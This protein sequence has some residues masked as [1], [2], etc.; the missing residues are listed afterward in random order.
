M[1]N[2][3][4]SGWIEVRLE[5]TRYTVQ[6]GRTVVIPVEIENTGKV[7]DHLEFSIL[8][9]PPEWLGAP[10][11]I[12]ML[13]VGE[14]RQVSLVI[15]PPPAT[16]LRPGVYPLQLRISSLRLQGRTIELDLLLTVAAESV[17]GTLAAYLAQQEYVVPP[18]G[19]VA[20]SLVVVNNYLKKDRFR[21]SA[22]GLPSGWISAD[23]A[24]IELKPGEEAEIRLEIT[25]PHSSTSLAG[26]YPFNL[27]LSAESEPKHTAALSCQLTV[28]PYYS[29]ELELL[30]PVLE[31]GD[32]GRVRLQNQGNEEDIYTL[33]FDSTQEK[34]SFHISSPLVEPAIPLSEPAGEARLMPWGVAHAEGRT[35]FRGD[36]AGAYQGAVM[37]IPPGQV[38]EIEFRVLSLHPP[39]FQQSVESFTVESASRRQ[40][41]RS[42]SGMAEIAP[43]AYPLM[44][45][46]VMLLFFFTLAISAVLLGM[47]AIQTQVA[48]VSTRGTPTPTYVVLTAFPTRTQTPT[49]TL[50]P[51]FTQTIMTPT[52]TTTGTQTLGTPSTTPTVSLTP[53][54]TQTG[55][56]VPP[57][58]TVTR[59]ATT[60][61][62]IFPILNTGRIAYD[63]TIGGNQELFVYD[64]SRLRLDLLYQSPGVDTQP[65]W[66]PD[67]KRLAFASNQDGNF[68]I[69]IL[70]L[71]TGVVYNLTRNPADDRYP[72]WSPDGQQILFTTDR[73]G[74][75]EIY[76]TT[77]DA[78]NI[79]NLTQNP[80]NDLQPNWF[81][82]ER[83]VFASDR[84][85]NLEIY[86]MNPD[87]SGQTNL[88]N[89]P[90]ADDFDPSGSPDA[91]LIAFTSNREGNLEIF[92][93]SLDGGNQTNLTRNS[94]QDETPTWSPDSQWIAFSSN[95]DA[96]W[97]VYVIRRDGSQPY[98]VTSLPTE[99][100][101]PSWTYP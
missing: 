63:T 14:T 54:P 34:L 75:Q 92:S 67:G 96:N 20:F 4:F 57:T 36:Q 86:L 61:E 12:V 22:A 17:Q 100:R 94:A 49:S 76:A 50:I 99:D 83:I 47:W 3:P 53:T 28:L 29:Y 66:S 95:R 32:T 62:I 78:I 26:I 93:M 68:E 82:N 81:I 18:G 48:W 80:A 1:T 89:N 43:V 77:L 71:E 33:R 97:D 5:V 13:P 37:R 23:P 88:S 56:L 87:G 73:D 35:W 31:P 101:S 85:K 8:G 72:A 24:R 90:G 25:P 51:T 44:S 64:T 27:R 6:P 16:G 79:V 40:V 41:R 7:I 46:T 70:N 42:L 91:S 58:A 65:A 52:Q 59:A 10:L 9:I 21:I 55:T 2:D 19:T 98:N 84:D 11:P 69:Y 38:M 74:N 15:Q 45:R 39:V 30:T 60:T